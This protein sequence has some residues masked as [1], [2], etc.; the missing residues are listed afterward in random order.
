MS[1]EPRAT[2]GRWKAR[3]AQS[4]RLP[5]SILW[6]SFHQAA[7][8]EFKPKTLKFQNTEKDNFVS[9]N[10]IFTKTHEMSI[11]KGQGSVEG[12]MKELPT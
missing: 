10:D 7:F 6:G 3:P 2:H 12:T 9:K 8:T 1:W 4:V 11:P 5:S